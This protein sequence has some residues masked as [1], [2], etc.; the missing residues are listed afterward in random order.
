MGIALDDQDTVGRTVSIADHPGEI[1][2]IAV[3]AAVALDA[4]L[5]S[6]ANGRAITAVSTNR[7]YAIALRAA[8]ASGQLIPAKLLD[9]RS[10]VV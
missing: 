8:S 6:D 10:A 4:P 3:G 2:E 5:K 9:P 1:V 7:P